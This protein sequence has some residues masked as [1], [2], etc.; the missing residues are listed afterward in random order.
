MPKD[1]V[2]TSLSDLG[3]K[4]VLLVDPDSTLFIQ[5]KKILTEQKIGEVIQCSDGKEATEWLKAN[6]PPDIIIQEW[7]IPK[8][9]GPA[10]L[11][12]VRIW[13]SILMVLAWEPEPPTRQ[14]A[15]H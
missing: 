5:I 11:Q 13:A 1:L 7:R 3:V 2:E 15:R 6:E 9:S 14:N 8:V 10:F 12:R 4:K